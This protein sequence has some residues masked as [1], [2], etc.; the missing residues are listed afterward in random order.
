M[1]PDD[2]KIVLQSPRSPDDAD[3]REI[4]MAGKP[5][6]HA[7]RSKLWFDNPDNPGMTALY[8]E[9]YLNFGLTAEELRSGRPIIGIAQTGSDLSP[10]NRHHLQLAHRVREGIRTAGGVALEFPCHPIQETGKRPTAALDRNLAYLSL[11]EVLYG[12]PLD[13]VVLMTGC[14]KTT[15]ACI[16]AAAT[17]N[18]PAI[19][20]S[21]GPMLNG[22]W[23]GERA[24]SG[25]VVWHA[26]QD[27]AAGRIDA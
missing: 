24:G 14:D 16:M 2:V 12:Y 22:W 17:V 21:G 8:L 20:L 3:F 7:L 11:V 23:K 15:P 10:C 9:R 27:L 1:D 18:A 19:V 4:R 25:T 26:R 5:R 6:E 13:G